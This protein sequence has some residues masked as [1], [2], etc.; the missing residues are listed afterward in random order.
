[1]EVITHARVREALA[2]PLAN[3]PDAV[4]PLRSAQGVE[5]HQVTRCPADNR[6]RKGGKVSS[7]KNQGGTPVRTR[8]AGRGLLWYVLKHIAPPVYVQTVHIQ[9]A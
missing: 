4:A 7:K 1:M 2:A 6:R 5:E 8:A 9:E 3:V